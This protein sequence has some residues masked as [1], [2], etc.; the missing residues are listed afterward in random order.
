MTR[1]EYVAT[2]CVRLDQA[3]A[4]PFRPVSLENWF[5]RTRECHE[6]ADILARALPELTPV[7]GWVTNGSYGPLGVSLAAH[8]VLRTA[9]GTLI[10]VTPL[11]DESLRGSM[12]FIEH[13]GAERLFREAKKL[14]NFIDCWNCTT[15]ETSE[16]SLTSFRSSSGNG[17]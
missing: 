17:P 7:R 6:N 16:W 15:Q 1:D 10:D 4:V 12:H 14:S 5:P 13:E 3:V 11:A 2:V 9:D 8:S